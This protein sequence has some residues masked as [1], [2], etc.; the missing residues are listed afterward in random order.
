MKYKIVFDTSADKHS[1]DRRYII[2]SSNALPERIATL[3]MQGRIIFSVAQ[4]I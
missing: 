3:Q 4:A 1:A 2:V